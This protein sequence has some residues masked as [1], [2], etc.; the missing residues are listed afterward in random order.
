MRLNREKKFG[1]LYFQLVVRI[2][3]RKMIARAANVC[4]A[5][6]HILNVHDERNS[7]SDRPDGAMQTAARP[8]LAAVAAAPAANARQPANL[9]RMR[10]AT[11][12]PN[13]RRV[14]TAYITIIINKYY[15]RLKLDLRSKNMLF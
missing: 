4:C 5:A 11:R 12:Q 10:N 6:R 7:A 1:L 3:G 14:N 15:F 9:R 8:K 13:V 2:T